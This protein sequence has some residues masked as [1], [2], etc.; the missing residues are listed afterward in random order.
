MS[1]SL[2]TDRLR[3]MTNLMVAFYD[4]ANEPTNDEQVALNQYS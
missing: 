1:C 2:R 4:Y 3:D